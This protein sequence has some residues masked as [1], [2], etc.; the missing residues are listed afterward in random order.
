MSRGNEL[1][2]I[3]VSTKLPCILSATLRKKV[4]PCL[5]I[6]FLVS[7]FLLCNRFNTKFILPFP[8]ACRNSTR[9]IEKIAV[10]KTYKSLR[11]YKGKATY[12]WWQSWYL[13]F[14]LSFRIRK[15]TFIQRSYFHTY[16]LTLKKFK[17]ICMRKGP[18]V[19]LPM[20]CWII[21]FLIIYFI[22]LTFQILKEQNVLKTK[23]CQKWDSFVLFFL[24]WKASH[25]YKLLET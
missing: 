4:F 25:K 5:L 24:D 20:L 10:T 12:I 17:C 7:M 3:T 6:G 13:I 21:F 19:L 15:S 2:L 16:C 9:K 1:Q 11:L 14:I 23:K 18:N 22:L 8:K